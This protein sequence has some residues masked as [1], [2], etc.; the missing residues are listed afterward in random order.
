MT[1][2]VK[3]QFRGVCLCARCG[4]AAFYAYLYPW[5]NR[6]KINLIMARRLICA[7]LNPNASGTGQPCC[8]FLTRVGVSMPIL[9]A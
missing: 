9:C 7:C 2:E 3:W 4:S 8:A 5:Q 1:Q 6:L